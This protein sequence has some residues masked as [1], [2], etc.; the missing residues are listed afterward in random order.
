MLEFLR[1]LIEE[2]QIKHKK[3]SSK[4]RQMMVGGLWTTQVR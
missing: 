1:S 2:A 4:A 3:P